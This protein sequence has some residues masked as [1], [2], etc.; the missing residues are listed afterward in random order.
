MTHSWN[1]EDLFFYYLGIELSEYPKKIWDRIKSENKE[2]R[3][4]LDI[5]SGPGAFSLAALNNGYDVQA[6]DI[7]RKHL[8]ELKEKNIHKERLKTFNNDWLEA[9]VEKS[10]ITI[11]AYSLSNTIN[12]NEGVAKII[13][14]TKQ[15]AYFISFNNVE[16]N[17]FP[18]R[19]FI[20][21]ERSYPKKIH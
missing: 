17:R 19:R 14:N 20:K 18:N 5:G 11:S 8:S 2:F 7:S 1:D 12:S 15:T 13:Y 6:V 10:D 16:K 21:K 4:V 9:P 3:S